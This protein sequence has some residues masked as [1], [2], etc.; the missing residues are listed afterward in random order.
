MAINPYN[1][2]LLKP[3]KEKFIS[4]K[5]LFFRWNSIKKYVPHP[6][7]IYE[8]GGLLCVNMG[9]H[10][11]MI[12]KNKSKFRLKSHLDWVHYTPKGLGTAITYGDV[13]V[14]YERQHQDTRSDPNIW[15][16]THEEHQLKTHYAARAGRASQL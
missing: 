14:Y 16:D 10:T 1:S 12:A 15:G 3:K 4:D 11:V 5:K 9:E 8:S 6:Q 13:E 7:N 2:P